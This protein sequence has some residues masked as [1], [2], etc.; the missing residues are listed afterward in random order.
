MRSRRPPDLREAIVAYANDIHPY[1][2]GHS[3]ERVVLAVEDL[4]AGRLGPLKPKPFMSRI[5]SLQI[6]KRLGYWGPAA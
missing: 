6:R 5:R 4:L 3:S 1:R 2:D